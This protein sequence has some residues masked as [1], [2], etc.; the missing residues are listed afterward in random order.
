MVKLAIVGWLLAVVGG[1]VAF[2]GFRWGVADKQAALEQMS[3]AYEAKL[4]HAG[5]EAEQR[6]Q[7]TQADA[8]ALQQ[9][10]QAE[11]DFQKLPDLPLK[12][13]FRPGGVLYVESEAAELFAC[14]IR[15]FRPATSDRAELDFSINARAFKD[16]GAIGSWVLARG[17]QL[18]FVKGG[19]KPWK[20]EVP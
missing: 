19:F 9:I 11:L 16:M 6:L 20:G 4:Q 18:E 17:D 5:A 13:V 12:L 7:K 8:A 15:L 3:A 14:R 2:G 1:A 10:Q